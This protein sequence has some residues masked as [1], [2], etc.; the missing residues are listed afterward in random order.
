[1]GDLFN[2]KEIIKKNNG[3]VTMTIVIVVVLA[4]LVA[5]GLS[6]EENS[7][8]LSEESLMSNSEEDVQLQE[9]NDVLENSII[10]NEINVEPV[11]SIEND[12]VLDKESDSLIKTEENKIDLNK[13]KSDEL[14]KIPVYSNSPYYVVN[15]NIPFFN[16]EDL[17]TLSYEEYSNLDSLRKMFCDSCLYWKRFNA[18]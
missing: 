18:N 10:N 14:F 13:L 7:T 9:K 2:L 6:P 12:K 8:S 4:I 15:N 16:D 11:E 1:M 5:V 3:K 17:V